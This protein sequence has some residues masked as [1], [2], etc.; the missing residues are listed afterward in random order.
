MSREE[1]KSGMGGGS[2][3]SS[4][5]EVGVWFKVGECTRGSIGC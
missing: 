5:T 2:D 4:G 1:V 3:T